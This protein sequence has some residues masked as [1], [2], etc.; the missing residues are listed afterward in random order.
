MKKCVLALGMAI[1]K[2]WNKWV[3]WFVAV[4]LIQLTITGPTV[5][6]AELKVE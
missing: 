1:Q 5:L 4:P 3:F 2:V 6:D